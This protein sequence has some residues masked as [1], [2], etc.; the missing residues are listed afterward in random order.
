M[1]AIATTA[2]KIFGFLLFYQW[3]WKI[4]RYKFKILCVYTRFFVGVSIWMFRVAYFFS[5]LHLFLIQFRQIVW[6]VIWIPQQNASNVMSVVYFVALC[7]W[8]CI[9]VCM[10]VCEKKIAKFINKRNRY[11]KRFTTSGQH[12]MKEKKIGYHVNEKYDF[13]MSSFANTNMSSE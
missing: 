11:D 4:S 7:H 10:C 8:V 1:I 9:N 12:W 13:T 5:L 3:L 2:R 6:K